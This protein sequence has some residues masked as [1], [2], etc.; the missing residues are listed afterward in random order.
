[1]A[2]KDHVTL[3]RS[4]VRAWNEWRAACPPSFVPDFS[5]AD[6]S[7]ES[8]DGA[9]LVGADLNGAT[10]I[11]GHLSRARLC[12]AQ[13]RNAYLSG[14]DLSGADLTGADFRH[15]SLVKANLNGAL[16]SGAQLCHAQF[17]KSSLISADV[18]GGDLKGANFRNANLSQACFKNA[19]VFETDFSGA[20][21]SKL[22]VS[23]AKA[24]S[25]QFTDIDLSTVIGL[26]TVS[27]LGPS[28]IGIDTLLKSRGAIPD[29]FL[30][31]CGVPDDIITYVPSLCNRPFDYYSCF[32]SHSTADIRFCERLYADLQAK[33]VRTWFFP[34]D[35]TWGKTVWGE[36]DKSIKIYDK[37][38][39]VCSRDS[40]QSEPVLREI[41]RALQR[42]DQERRAGH[43]KH[44]LFPV[45]LDDFVFNGWEHERKAD[46]LRMV[47]G[48]FRE[49]QSLES[50]YAAFERLL[51]ALQSKE[52]TSGLPGIT[53]L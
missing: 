46:L 43:P 33:N 39:V 17:I 19:E 6:L 28:S 27:H 10:I 9:N 35:A 1:M 45:T 12:G 7:S 42:E 15:A 31:G 29:R 30:R 49:W 16:L 36:I 50:Y 48:N 21:V 38:V 20:Q 18:T 24:W 32:I 47:V 25:T 23:N 8:L 14:A 41:E 44:I 26:S 4:G 5:G 53:S 40:L 37:L 34:E 52:S 3:L 11:S 51:K 22:D 2:N 13:A